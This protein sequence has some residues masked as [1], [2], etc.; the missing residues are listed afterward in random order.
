MAKN[1]N[2]AEGRLWFL[3]NKGKRQ[4]SEKE[5]WIPDPHLLAFIIILYNYDVEGEVG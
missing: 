2:S 4:V 5:L 1:R 3:W